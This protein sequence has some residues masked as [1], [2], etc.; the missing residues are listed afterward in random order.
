MAIFENLEKITC[1]T[2]GFK[3]SLTPN[4]HLQKLI[5][6]LYKSTVKSKCR[7]PDTHREY[8]IL[9]NQKVIVSGVNHLKEIRSYI[10]GIRIY[11]GVKTL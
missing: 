8:P 10:Y 11:K 1:S 7:F 4:G 2:V 6:S 5:L 3:K 9:E